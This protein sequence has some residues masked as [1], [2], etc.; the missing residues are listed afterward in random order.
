MC[1][2]GPAMSTPRLLELRPGYP[3]E[4]D[5]LLLRPL[6]GADIEA[7]VAYRSQP[8]V[9]RFVPFE[10]MD[11]RAVLEKIEGPW[12]RT[13]ITAEGD[14]LTLG[15]ELKESS[16]LIG[17]MMLRFHSLEHRG[18]EVGW[19]LNPTY[20]GRGYATEAAH[21]ML[22]LAFDL[23]GLHR[24]TARVDARNE[25]SAR[26]GDRLGMR[27]EAHLLGNEWFKGEW[28]DEIDMAILEEEWVAQHA[29]GLVRCSS[30]RR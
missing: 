16:Q 12:S 4:T 5:R 28:S 30:G 19:V 17:D 10:P 14:A 3:V 6:C 9:C 2:H 22:H 25:A 18:G 27:R 1:E 20:S 11:T 13:E 29:A 24:V 23:L 8:D 26:V 15:V 21:G 7:L